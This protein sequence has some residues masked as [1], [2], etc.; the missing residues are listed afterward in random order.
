M[1]MLIDD[2]YEDLFHR[3]LEAIREQRDVR[4]SMALD[5]W[6]RAKLAA[7]TRHGGI[8]RRLHQALAAE[9]LGVEYEATVGWFCGGE[10]EIIAPQSRADFGVL[11]RA[12]GIYTHE[13]LIDT[14]HACINVERNLR[15]RCGK[16][17]SRLLTQI[18]AG[19]NFETAMESAKVLGTPVEHVAAAVVL[20]EVEAVRKLDGLPAVSV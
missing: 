2:P 6:Q 13:S 19:Q 14:T 11:A 4:S 8:R 5:L 9:G 15:R 20:R 10:D 1:V 18:A 16:I 7:L 12:T 3:L 17:L